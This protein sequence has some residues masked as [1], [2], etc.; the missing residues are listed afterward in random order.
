MSLFCSHIIYNFISVMLFTD[1]IV[2][3]VSRYGKWAVEKLKN[4]VL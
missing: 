4:F 3:I 1:T 2:C